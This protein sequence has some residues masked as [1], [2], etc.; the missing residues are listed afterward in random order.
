MNSSTVSPA[1]PKSGTANADQAADAKPA[2]SESSRTASAALALDLLRRCAKELGWTDEALAI[3]LKND[4]DYRGYVN[5]V[6]N[7][8]K[9]LSFTFLESLPDDLL[10]LYYGRRAEQLGSIVVTPID[11]IEAA[12][13]QFV[14][15]L[16]ALISPA[17][18]LKAG[19]PLKLS[20][21]TPMA[22]Q[23]SA[24]R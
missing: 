14:S 6:F 21:G 1:C 5:K 13:R 4:R 7:G 24:V 2:R 8:L 17:L 12:K 20:L 10:A 15:A 19:A 3:H 11:D 18:P 16:L 9:P 23:R 22:A